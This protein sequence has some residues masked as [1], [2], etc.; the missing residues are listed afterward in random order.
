MQDYN[1]LH[2]NCFEITLELGCTKF[3]EASDL[4]GYWED[5]KP[6]LI[7]YIQMV[8]FSSAPSRCWTS[9]KGKKMT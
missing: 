7:K 4:K 2:T 1:Y 9:V 6:A 5:N 8:R 3:P